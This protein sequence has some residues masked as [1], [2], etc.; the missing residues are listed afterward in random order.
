[1]RV[2]GREGEPEDRGEAGG[3]G[4]G[5]QR[6]RERGLAPQGRSRGRELEGRRQPVHTPPGRL[7]EVMT[8]QENGRL[9]FGLGLHEERRNQNS[10]RKKANLC[11]WIRPQY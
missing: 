6:L 4:A 3:R 5:T 11:L 9:G 10:P 2:H 8:A 1:M 7:L